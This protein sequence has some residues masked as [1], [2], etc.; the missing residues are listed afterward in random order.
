MVEVLFAEV[1]QYMGIVQPHFLFCRE[2]FFG[3]CG[4]P[5]ADSEVQGLQEIT[6]HEAHGE[7]GE[8][9][10]LSLPRRQAGYHIN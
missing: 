1:V 10:V 8:G 5:A 4:T 7:G 9:E 3:E 6:L 2:N